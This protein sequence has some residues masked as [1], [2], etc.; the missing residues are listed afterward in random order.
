MYKDSNGNNMG[1]VWGSRKHTEGKFIEVEKIYIVPWND[2]FTFSG[3]PRRGAS[4]D[5]NPVNASI[6]CST[7]SREGFGSNKDAIVAP[8][9]EVYLQGMYTHCR[10]E[11]KYTNDQQAVLAAYDPV[12]N[13]AKTTYAA[14][15]EVLEVGIGD[16]W[17]TG[18]D[19]PT[20]SSSAAGEYIEAPY[21][22]LLP[23]VVIGYDFYTP[24]YNYAVI[25][26]AVGKVNSVP[27]G[28]TYSVVS[29]TAA[30]PAERLRL[31]AINITQEYIDPTDLT[32]KMYHVVLTFTDRVHHTWNEFY[33]PRQPQ[34]DSDLIIKEDPSHPGRIL[35]EVTDKSGWYKKGRDAY[36]TVDFNTIFT[37]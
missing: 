21:T 23:N 19:S 1:E 32:R 31:D 3:C 2:R 14:G 9:G 18:S 26:D 8:N 6:R 25:N 35:W 20:G 16:T 17:Q 36:E 12:T 37:T 29:G 7:I 34:R 11:A 24:Y 27:Y 13:P 5:S 33:R 15:S 22:I 10:V 4:I 30:I 28:Y